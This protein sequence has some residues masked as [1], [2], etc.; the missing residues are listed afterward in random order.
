MFGGPVPS[1]LQIISLHFKSIFVVTVTQ[2]HTK[3]LYNKFT[4]KCREFHQN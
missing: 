2:K 4:K 1:T 3:N